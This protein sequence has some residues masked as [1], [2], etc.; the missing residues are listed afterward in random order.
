[1]V[2]NSPLSLTLMAIGSFTIISAVLGALVQHDFRKLLAFHAVSQVGYMVLGIGTGLPV[3]V[4]G[5]LFHMFNNALYKS[6]LFLCGGAVEQ[7]SGSAE[8]SKLGGLARPMPL[9]FAAFLI[10]ALSISGVPPFNGFFS[11]WLIYQSLVDLARISP[12][13]IIWLTAAMLGSAFTLASF[14]K[15]THA[16]FLGQWSETTAKTKE[17]S[18]LMWLPMISLAALCVIFGVFAFNLP[19][20]YLIAPV[21]G[22]IPISGVWAPGTATWLILLGLL[23]GLLI[24]WLGRVRKTTTKPVFI[25]GEN[26]PA[27]MTKVSG[28]DFY[29]TVRRW[30]PLDRVYLAAERRAFDIYE[31]GKDAAFAVAGGLSRLH[32]GL[33]QTY[34]VWLLLGLAGLLLYLVR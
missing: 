4:A 12:Y 34:L 32:N 18:W 33:L 9:T 20:R 28:V 6:C 21:V 22:R 19:L 13:W 30:G 29:D 14:V 11:K 10:A 3:G 7:R 16:I 27:E 5:G 23:L 8:L 24:Y 17:V 26:L 25:G 2:P 31:L 1:V 15:L